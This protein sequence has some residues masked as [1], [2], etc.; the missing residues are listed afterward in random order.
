MPGRRQGSGLSAVQTGHDVVGYH[1][2]SGAVIDP[3]GKGKQVPGAEGFQRPQVCDHSRVGV[4]V[5]PIAGEMLEHTAHAVLLIERR[6]PGRVVRRD[7]RGLAQGAGVHKVGGIQGHIAHRGKIHIDP[8][9]GEEVY[10]FLLGLQ[11]VGHP[12]G[13]IKVTGRSKGCRAQLG[14]GADP[15]HGAA[16]LIH[17]DEQGDPGGVLA[18]SDLLPHLGGGQA[19]EIPAEQHQAAELM[20][21]HFCGGIGRA[22]DKEHLLHLFLQGHGQQ[23]PILRGPF[24]VLDLHGHILSPVSGKGHEKLGD[25]RPCRRVP[26][27]DRPFGIAVHDPG[28]HGPGQGG[29]CIAGRLRKVGKARK[30][31]NFRPDASRLGNHIII[32]DR[33]HLLPADGEIGAEPIISGAA[34]HTI[35]LGPGNVWLRVVRGGV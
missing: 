9:A 8:Q 2:A 16:L 7:L 27:Q 12:T 21:P 20:L 28:V 14:I 24:R 10:L 11:H 3:P 23:Q 26:G 6:L 17:S 33:G 5:V 29:H 30:L 1:H 13:G 25:L 22:A 32:Q 4:P 31:R 19:A 18:A 15:Y 35:R 34:D